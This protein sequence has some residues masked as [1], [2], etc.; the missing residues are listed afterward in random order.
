MGV[1]GQYTPADSVYNE[2]GHIRDLEF[3]DSAIIFQYKFNAAIHRLDTTKNIVDTLNNYVASKDT[4]TYFIHENDT[5]IFASDNDVYNVQ[6]Q[7]SIIQGDT[8]RYADHFTNNDETD[9]VYSSDVAS[10]ITEQ[11]T[12]NWNAAVSG[13]GSM[14]AQQAKDSITDINIIFNPAAIVLNKKETIYNN[15]QQSSILTFTEPSNNIGIGSSFAVTINTNE[16]NINFP[17]SW[18][19]FTNEYIGDSASY[20]VMVQNLGTHWIYSVVKLDNDVL[21]DPVITSGVMAASNEYVTINFNTGIYGDA[22]ATN[23]VELSDFSVT[24]NQNGGSAT[25]W[26]EDS[27]TD[28]IGA[29]LTGG[30]NIVRIYGTTTGIADGNEYVVIIPA[31]GSS[32]YNT[33]GV[34]MSVVQTTGNISLIDQ[35]IATLTA[36]VLTVDSIA[37]TYAY[38]SWT[39]PNTSPNETGFEVSYKPDDSTTWVIWD[40]SGVD[41]INDTITGLTSLE[42]YDFSVIALGDGGVT[43]NNSSRSNIITD[44]TTLVTIID[45]IDNMTL[46]YSF[47]DTNYFDFDENNYITSITDRGESDVTFTIG[48]SVK[49]IQGLKAA[50]TNSTGLLNHSPALYTRDSVLIAYV[51]T[52]IYDWVNFTTSPDVKIV[53]TD[54]GS[55]RF[56]YTNSTTYSDQIWGAFANVVNKLNAMYEIQGQ[57]VIFVTSKSDTA[58][59]YVN[60]TLVLKKL[61]TGT[62]GIR[63]IIGTLSTTAAGMPLGTTQYLNECRVYTKFY[64]ITERTSLYD[65]FVDKYNLTP[66]VYPTVSNI[67]IIGDCNPDSTVTVTFD[68]NQ[69]GAD[70]QGDVYVKWD[71]YTNNTLS[72][73]VSW[74][75][76]NS[77]GRN[78]NTFTATVPNQIGQHLYVNLIVYDQANR[79]YKLPVG[80]VRTITAP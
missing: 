51:M 1:F 67:Q 9:P 42:N 69:G 10:G 58:F 76:N 59:F 48:D 25:A 34:S 62:N 68:Y 63:N 64:S 13:V 61:M 72:P 60:N 29:N 18:N 7:V 5:S 11:D 16:Q 27:I 20:V 14:T 38:L 24:F 75:L 40:T 57:S 43:S 56:A 65:Y 80:T 28:E 23:P 2:N 78:K 37:S 74:T 46:Y 31:D 30:E 52:Y 12:A 79:C 70:A 44:S 47:D 53:A 71:Y 50:R 15:Y 33:D 32:I 3:G 35:S 66:T 17:S 41:D 26:Q 77:A 39:D 8:A 54:V 4:L 45:D 73:S 22:I 49:Y 19:E 21:P 36:P 55:Q 6:T